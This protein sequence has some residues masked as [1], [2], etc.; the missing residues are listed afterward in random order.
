MLREDLL[1]QTKLFSWT[2]LYR[3][4]RSGKVAIALLSR[5][6]IFS[7]IELMAINSIDRYLWCCILAS[8]II[9]IAYYVDFF[10][11]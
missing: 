7:K 10:I 8:L 5:P 11:N 2:K 1:Y 9:S 6:H 4:P 3:S